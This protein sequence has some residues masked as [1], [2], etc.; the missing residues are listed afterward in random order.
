ME[1]PANNAT[2]A[3]RIKQWFRK[4]GIRAYVG[5]RSGESGCYFYV[6]VS[7]RKY[8]QAKRLFENYN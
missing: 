5:K 1:F 8:P 3:V 7:E 6:I 4:N 2:E